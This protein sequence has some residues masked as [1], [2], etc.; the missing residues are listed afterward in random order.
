LPS[1]RAFQQCHQFAGERHFLE[2]IIAVVIGDIIGAQRNVDSRSQDLDQW[3][4]SCRI[5]HV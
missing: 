1:A 4:D 2:H 3:R 5:A